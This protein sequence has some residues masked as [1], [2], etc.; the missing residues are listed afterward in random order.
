MTLHV[1]VGVQVFYRPRRK[2]HLRE[3]SPDFEWGCWV[4]EILE[5]GYWTEFQCQ[6]MGRSR[7][8]EKAM[9]AMLQLNRLFHGRVTFVLVS[10]FPNV[11]SHS[12]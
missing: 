12:P 2:I 11:R 9:A 4:E 1:V 8:A 6:A 5:T 7:F 10:Y 3:R